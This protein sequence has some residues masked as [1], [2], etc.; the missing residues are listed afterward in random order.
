MNGFREEYEEI[1]RR[2]LRGGRLPRFA[3]N[4]KLLR[5]GFLREFIYRK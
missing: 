4:D 1:K 3:R 5:G 2:F